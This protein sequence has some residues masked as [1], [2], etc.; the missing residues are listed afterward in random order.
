MNAAGIEKGSEE[1]TDLSKKYAKRLADGEIKTLSLSEQISMVSKDLSSNPMLK[2]SEKN[3]V[4]SRKALA[5]IAEVRNLKAEGKPVS[6]MER[7]I[8]RT[9][10]ELYNADTRSVQEIQRF[11]EGNLLA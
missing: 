10:S 7:V 3:S 4:Q 8:E 9:V 2:I 5:T 11:L 6:E 1:W